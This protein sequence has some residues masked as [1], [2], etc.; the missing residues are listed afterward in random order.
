MNCPQWIKPS[1]EIWHYQSSMFDKFWKNLE[2]KPATW[3][4]LYFHIE[5][6]IEITG[7]IARV[8]VPNVNSI[9]SWQI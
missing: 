3:P 7:H 2:Q 5:P 8:F 6:V 1:L 9:V 4:I